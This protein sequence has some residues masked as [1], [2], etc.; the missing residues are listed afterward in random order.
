MSKLSND[1][2]SNGLQL[3]DFESFNKQQ[4]ER[5]EELTTELLDNLRKLSGPTF[6]SNILENEEIQ[7]RLLRRLQVMIDH[8][9]KVPDGPQDKLGP[10]AS[11]FFSEI[12]DPLF[13]KFC[14]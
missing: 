11:G 14:Q 4:K 10:W 7:R 6:E 2:G 13:D 5:L 1:T 9:S 12:A 8:Q 3:P